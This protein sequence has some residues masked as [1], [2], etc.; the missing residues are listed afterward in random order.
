VFEIDFLLRL[1]DFG[2]DSDTSTVGFVEQSVDFGSHCVVDSNFE[3]FVEFDLVEFDL[4]DLIDCVVED[5]I[6]V[7]NCASFEVSIGNNSVD[8]G[9]WGN[10]GVDLGNFGVDFASGS[11]CFDNFD[12][13]DNFGVG[14]VDFE[15]LGVGIVEIV[16]IVGI[17]DFGVEMIDFEGFGVDFV[18]VGVIVAECKG[19]GDCCIG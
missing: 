15:G 8:W 19:I 14:I 17:V 18:I 5:C 10:F 6:D 11:S 3:H 2:V 7:D 4:S 1:L 9:N 16:G 12:N 13:F